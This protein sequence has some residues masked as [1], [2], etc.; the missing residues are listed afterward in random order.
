MPNTPKIYWA[1]HEHCHLVLFY[2]HGAVFDP[3]FSARLYVH[4]IQEVQPHSKY[5]TQTMQSNAHFSC[6]AS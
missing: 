4:E 2:K 6:P 5:P 1:A 3:C